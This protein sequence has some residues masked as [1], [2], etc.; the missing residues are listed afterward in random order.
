M[1]EQREIDVLA[2][3]RLEPHPGGASREGLERR[4]D[5][6]ARGVSVRIGHH[7]RPRRGLERGHQLLDM[8]SG[9]LVLERHGMEGHEDP[10]ASS[11]QIELSCELLSGL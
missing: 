8:P 6:P 2:E 7:E 3:R 4:D 10:R 9:V 11:G 1:L 5:R